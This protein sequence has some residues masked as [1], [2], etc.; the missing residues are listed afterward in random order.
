MPTLMLGAIG[1]V[2]GDIGT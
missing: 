2:F 1:V